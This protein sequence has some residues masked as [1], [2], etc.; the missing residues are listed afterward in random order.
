MT[1]AQIKRRYTHVKR[2]GGDW[3]CWLRVDHQS[4]RLAVC[5]TKAE[6]EWWREMLVIALHRMI[7]GGGK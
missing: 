4:F 5:G 3:Y 6:V 1:T 7:E 2:L